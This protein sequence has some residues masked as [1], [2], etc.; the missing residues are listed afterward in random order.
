LKDHVFARSSPRRGPRKTDDAGDPAGRVPCYMADSLW[1]ECPF[2]PEALIGGGRAPGRFARG[3]SSRVLTHRKRSRM[4]RRDRRGRKR[5]W[6]R[7][8]SWQTPPPVAKPLASDDIVLMPSIPSALLY[9]RSDLCFR[10]GDSQA[11]KRNRCCRPKSPGF[12]FF[13]SPPTSPPDRR[14]LWVRSTNQPLITCYGA[15]ARPASLSWSCYASWT[16]G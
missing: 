4:R 10:S 13:S 6:L 5:R 2:H 15:N 9:L 8:E 1:V 7:A 16:P 11:I 14:S 3:V 12:D